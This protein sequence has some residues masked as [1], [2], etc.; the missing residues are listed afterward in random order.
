MSPRRT[1]TP[2]IEQEQEQEQAKLDAESSVVEA[3]RLTDAYLELV[4][5]RE[6]ERRE[7]LTRYRELVFRAADNGGQLTRAD[8]DQL[9]EITHAIG[10]SVGDFQSDVVAVHRD[11]EH[12]NAIAALV[13]QQIAAAREYEKI[14]QEQARLSQEFAAIRDEYEGRGRLLDLQVV[15][16]RREAE[17]VENTVSQFSRDAMKRGDRQTY[18]RSTSERVFGRI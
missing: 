10:L 4:Q 1:P 11:R 2:V 16:L 9:V 13:D 8:L 5:R 18:D 12:E 14:T 15:K 7:S 6:Q 3:E 17:R